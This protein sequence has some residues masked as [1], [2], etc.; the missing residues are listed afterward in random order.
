MS[1]GLELNHKSGKIE[2]QTYIYSF[3]HLHKNNNTYDAKCP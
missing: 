3:Y 1:L 2:N